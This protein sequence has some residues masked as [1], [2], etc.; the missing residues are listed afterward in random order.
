MFSAIEKALSNQATPED[1]L[2]QAAKE[3]LDA[4]TQ[5]GAYQ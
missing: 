1:S 4:M 5:A 3:S 2:N